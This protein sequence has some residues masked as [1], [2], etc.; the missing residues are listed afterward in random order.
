MPYVLILYPLETS[1]NQ[2]FSVVFRSYR[3]RT[4]ARYGF[5]RFMISVRSWIFGYVHIG[6]FDNG[7]KFWDCVSRKRSLRVL[8]PTRSGYVSKFYCLSFLVKFQIL[9][10]LYEIRGTENWKWITWFRT[11]VWLGPL[12]SNP[13]INCECV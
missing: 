12:I 11:P 4:L 10:C 1:E 7:S 6:L 13:R 2:R 8:E 3:M 9:D 5:N